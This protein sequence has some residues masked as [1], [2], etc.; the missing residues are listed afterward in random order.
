MALFALDHNY[1]APIIEQAKPFL[2]GVELVFIGE[3]DSRL[4][5]LDDWEL[6]LALHHHPREWDGMISNDTSM[7]DQERELAVLG[8]THLTLVAPVAAGH[9]PIALPAKS[10]PIS[11]T[12]PLA[13]R[14]ASP[15]SG[16]SPAAPAA[17]ITPIGS[18]RSSQR[19]LASIPSTYARRR[20]RQRQSSSAIRFRHNCLIG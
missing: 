17:A 9:D 13:Q 4:S 1:P 7:L 20:L 5:E 3:I 2:S 6:L 19:E 18:S 14:C 8:Y 11:R 10:W 16:D 12:S 15:R